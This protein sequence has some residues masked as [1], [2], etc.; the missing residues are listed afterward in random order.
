MASAILLLRGKICVYM[1]YVK[2]CFLVR[3]CSF[4][5]CPV[6]ITFIHLSYD[7]FHYV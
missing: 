5:L 3:K 1:T 4:C 7:V 6:P 2:P